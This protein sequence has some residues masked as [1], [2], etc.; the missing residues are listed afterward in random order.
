MPGQNKGLGIEFTMDALDG[1]VNGRGQRLVH[2]LGIL[3][4]CEIN[5]PEAPLAQQMVMCELCNGS[6]HIYRKPLVITANITAISQHR[7]LMVAGWAQPG[8]CVMSIS[9]LEPRKVS[10]FDRITFTWS[11]PYNEGQV[12]KRGSGSPPLPANVDRLNYNCHKVL[13]CEDKDGHEYHEGGDF[14]TKNRFLIWTPGAAP[15]RN[16]QYTVKYEG[17]LE[18][19]AFSPPMERRDQNLDIGQRIL[20]RKK[21]TVDLLDYTQGL[22][23]KFD[24]NI[25]V[26]DQ[27]GTGSAC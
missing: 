8:D 11:Q 15:L 26:A 9:P 4:P 1:F 22:H 2:E 7:N 27:S 6:K 18:W 14:I 25:D 23:T 17:Y 13:H 21:H 10:D 24:Q 20:L 5:A 19:I 16:V 3:C 12:I